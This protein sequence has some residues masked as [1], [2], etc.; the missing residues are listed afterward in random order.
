VTADAIKAKKAVGADQ[1]KL[2]R[3]QAIRKAKEA[4][5]AKAASSKKRSGARGGDKV[6]NRKGGGGSQRSTGKGA[7]R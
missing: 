1:R 6:Q 5:K 3:E 7:G 2:L 4:A